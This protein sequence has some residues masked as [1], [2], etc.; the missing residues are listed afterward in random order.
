MWN[1][2]NVKAVAYKHFNGI[3]SFVIS[4]NSKETSTNDDNSC[5]LL[6]YTNTNTDFLDFQNKSNYK[7]KNTTF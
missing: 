4:Y 6:K 3:T 1:K 7:Y 5:F 2:I